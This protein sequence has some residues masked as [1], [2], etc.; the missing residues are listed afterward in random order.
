[1]AY[2]YQGFTIQMLLILYAM[3]WSYR[4]FNVTNNFQEEIYCYF[5]MW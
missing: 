2:L 4:I 3:K 1:M 5:E